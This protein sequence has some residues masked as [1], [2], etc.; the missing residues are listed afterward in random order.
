MEQART[1]VIGLGNPLRGDDGAG[2]AVAQALRA[3][4]APAVEIAELYAGGIRLLEALPG[5]ER[6][7]I[8]DAM[9]TGTCAPGT[10]RCFD[11]DDLPATR[12][13]AS[14]HDLDLRTALELGRL[15]GLQLPSRILVWGIEV[16]E[17]AR[18]QEGLSAPV[19]RGV[20]EAVRGLRA[21][22]AAP[23][24]PARAEGRP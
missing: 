1:L 8:V 2:L 14:T 21:L 19:A 5:H 13:V 17:V 6:A 18:L 11:L 16:Q 10:V 23:D 7:V 15:A 24:W 22:L 12:Y 4:G 9:L 20:A 3:E